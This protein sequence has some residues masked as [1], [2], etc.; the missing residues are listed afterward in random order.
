MKKYYLLL[1]LIINVNIF[2]QQQA[3]LQ[4]IVLTPTIP[5]SEMITIAGNIPELGNWNA[6]K[7]ILS[8]INDTTYSKEFEL[9]MGE[10]IEYKI[11][12]GS[13]ENEAVN[14]DGSIPQNSN[15]KIFSDTT[16]VVK[17]FGWKDQFEQE[18][19]GQITGNVEY[20][21]NI[22]SGIL[23]PRDLIIW[24]PPSYYTTFEKEY[25]V[26]YLHDGQNIFDPKTCS[27]GYDWRF[28]EVADSLI[29]LGEIEELIIVGIYNT[30]FRWQE[31]SP[32][33]TGSAYMKLIV[34]KIKPLLDSLY[35]TFPQRE[36]TFV[37]GSSMGGLISFMLIWE[38]PEIFSKALCVSP[39]F[40]IENIDYVSVIQNYSNK[41]KPVKIYFD[42]GGIGLEEKLQPGIDEMMNTLNSKGYKLNQD[43]VWYKFE[44]AQHSERDWAKRVWRMLKFL[45][46]RN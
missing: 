41:K 36:N 11:T 26:L 39:A 18:V 20:L 44:N 19:H 32:G 40:K 33:D 31:Y 22:Q 5:H 34:H 10:T 1:F 28:D 12:R 45:S 3:K 6:S 37:G 9:L 8:K 2:G 30:K 14:P 24:L 46:D 43:F 25:P 42:N 27:F 38:Y 13:W 35:R 17:I 23:A 16:V 15:L 21:E 7:I 4:I 29:K